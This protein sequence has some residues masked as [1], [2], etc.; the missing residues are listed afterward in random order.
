M[1]TARLGIAID[2]G[3]TKTTAC[4]AKLAQDGA[5]VI[6]GQATAGAANPAAVGLAVTKANI[7][8][9]IVEAV[10]QA[11]VA[12][13]P[14]ECLLA[15]LAGIEATGVHHELATWAAK[16]FRANHASFVTDVELLHF[17]GSRDLPAVVLISGTGS[18][19]FGRDAAGNQARTG[20]RGYLMGDEGSGF[21][22][23]QRG[24]HA[25]VRALDHAAPTTALVAL[26]GE[27]LGSQDAGAWTKEIYGTSDPRDKISQMSRRVAQ[28]AQQGDP[29]AIEILDDAG[30]QLA[31]LAKSVAG[32]LGLAGDP[33]DLVLAGGILLN[34][35]GVRHAL[36]KHL[37][38]LAL[39]IATQ[40]IIEHPA[41]AAAQRCVVIS[42][43]EH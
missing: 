8:H 25:A 3:G 24:L 10:A 14:I 37:R 9:A 23:G 2:G 17:A 13:E 16:E 21:W 11:N 35:N 29:V 26:I 43:D 27:D 33:F 20:G 39:P 31:H 32:Q 42:N 6:L 19:A 18:V 22:I 15:G 38:S 30:R 40:R 12:D 41:A 28:A 5:P 7:A 36:D 1:P 4:I 34:V